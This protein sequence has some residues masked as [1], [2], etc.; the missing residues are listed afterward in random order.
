MALH[1]I[2]GQLIIGDDKVYV[3]QIVGDIESFTYETLEEA[4]IKLK[5]L[6][7][8]EINGRKYYIMSYEQQSTI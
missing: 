2:M 4:Q 7:D 6:Q 1:S 3:A 8:L 5:E